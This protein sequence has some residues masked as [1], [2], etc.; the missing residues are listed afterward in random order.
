MAKNKSKQTIIHKLLVKLRL[1]CLKINVVV[2]ML[3]SNGDRILRQ[4]VS[5]LSRQLTQLQL[6]WVTLFEAHRLESL[7]LLMVLVLLVVILHLPL[8]QLLQLS[9]VGS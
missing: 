9:P 4:Q 3:R 8:G 1:Q 7:K 6:V 2:R 5:D